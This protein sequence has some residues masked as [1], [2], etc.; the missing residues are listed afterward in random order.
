LP[1][2]VE[3]CGHSY[4]VI[5]SH[6]RSLAIDPHDGGSIGIETCRVG[7]DYIIV[8]H[9]NIDHNAVEAALGEGSIVVKHRTGSFQLGPFKVE[10]YRLYHD[11]ARGRLRGEVTAYLIEVAG[12]RLAHLG[13]VGHLLSS[14]E[15]RPF[16]GVDLLMIPVGGVY[17]ISAPEAWAIIEDLSP[18][19][20]LPL[21][22]WVPGSILPLDPLERFLN[23]ARAGRARI[24]GRRFTVPVQA[25]TNQTVIVVPEHPGRS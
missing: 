5:R 13:D 6:G 20:V 12:V 17:T 8:T 14:E 16:K 10:G 1:V 9:D 19:A 25:A 4:V 3:W 7:A 15:A 24:Q 23:V 22:Y 2:E 21:H 18:R 11:K